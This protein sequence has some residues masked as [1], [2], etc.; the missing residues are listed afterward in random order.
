MRKKLISW[1]LWLLVLGGVLL[2]IA[3]FSLCV[4]SVDIS[5]KKILRVILEGKATTEYSILFDIRLPRI[6]LGFAVGGALSLAGVILQ[7]MF[8]NPL[9]EP[10]TL[11]ISGGAALGVCLNIV[12]GLHHKFTL[13]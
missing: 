11:G 13:S 12:L 7:G 8:R 9:V 5:L 3:I 1:F 2:G 4:G 10:Y 6:I